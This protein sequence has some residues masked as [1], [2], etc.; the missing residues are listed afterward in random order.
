[1]V[2]SIVAVRKTDAAVQFL[3]L[4]RLPSKRGANLRQQQTQNALESKYVKHY[5]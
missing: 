4:A 3:K 1:V 5:D 2:C